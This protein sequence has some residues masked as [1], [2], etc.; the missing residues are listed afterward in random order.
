MTDSSLASSP[1][2]QA[3]A[4]F[5]LPPP[6]AERLEKLD[7]LLHRLDAVSIPEH[8]SDVLSSQLSVDAGK[9][10]QLVFEARGVLGVEEALDQLAAVGSNTGSLSSDLSWVDEVFE[11]GGVY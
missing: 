1:C 4:V 9:A 3:T 7:L 8:E 2:H 5:I 6:T 10:V 11:D